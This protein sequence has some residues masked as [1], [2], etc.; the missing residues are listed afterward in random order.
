MIEL[1]S[2]EQIDKIRK[3]SQLVVAV[4]NKIKKEARPG[5]K[6]K[7]LD[8]IAREFIFEK[9][10]R[11]AFLGYR[12]YP[13]SI[14]TSVN[15][16][17]VHGI[18][19]ERVLKEADILSIDVGV[20]LNGYFSDAAV[21]VGVGNISSEASRLIEVTKKA[22]YNAIEATRIGKRISD[23]SFA[24]QEFVEAN[25]FSVIREFVGHG[26]GSALHEEPQIPN[27][28]ASGMGVRIKEGMVFA[29]EPM[30]SAGRW[31]VEVLEDGWTAVTRDRSLA[32]H[33]EHTIVATEQEAEILTKGI[34]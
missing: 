20:E 18:P 15:E 1:K 25:N 34:M 11:P 6:T 27:F 26:I 30:V 3:A 14:C 33:F 16:E 8:N 29:I 13:K 31:E 2:P 5:I 10:A 17:I 9:G 23:I 28:G 4:I 7:E 19:G 32:A 24:I 12:G 21:T 22:L